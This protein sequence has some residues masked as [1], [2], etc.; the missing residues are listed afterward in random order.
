MHL[1]PAKL[2]FDYCISNRSDILSASEEWETAPAFEEY[3][4]RLRFDRWLMVPPLFS[5]VTWAQ[6]GEKLH[7]FGILGFVLFCRA[8]PSRI[9]RIIITVDR[10]KFVSIVATRRWRKW[11][12]WSR[13]VRR[14]RSMAIISEVFWDGVFAFFSWFFQRKGEVRSM[15]LCWQESLCLA[16]VP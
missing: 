14:V 3:R 11:T 15:R 2:F 4:Q 6:F 9:S 1:I 10:G 5:P 7:S 16:H 8:S 12:T 13:R